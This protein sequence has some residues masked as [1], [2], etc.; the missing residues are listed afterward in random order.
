MHSPDAFG[1]CRVHY[2]IFPCD[3]LCSDVG[4]VGIYDLVVETALLDG[5][6][7]A[8]HCCS[9]LAMCRGES[10]RG[11][12]GLTGR[13]LRARTYRQSVVLACASERRKI[14]LEGATGT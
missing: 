5:C 14:W 13:C 11:S 4:V 1:L 7:R 9:W 6:V 8:A 3:E 2:H 12:D 10:G